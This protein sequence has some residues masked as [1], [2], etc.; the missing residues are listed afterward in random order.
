M[1][2]QLTKKSVKSEKELQKIVYQAFEQVLFPVD[3]STATLK[4]NEPKLQLVKSGPL[5]TASYAAPKE[6]QDYARRKPAKPYM[7][8]PARQLQQSRMRQA[9]TAWKTTPES[10]RIQWKQIAEKEHNYAVSLFCGIYML[11]LADNRPI[12][13]PLIPNP[14]LLKYY[15]CRKTK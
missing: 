14:E 2:K 8:T 11:L 7:L 12:P 3:L 1:Y 13:N 15:H 6:R 4:Y 9:T 10:I 5:G